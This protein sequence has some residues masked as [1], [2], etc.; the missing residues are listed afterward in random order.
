VSGQNANA[1]SPVR[2]IPAI[3]VVLS[4]AAA[5]LGVASAQTLTAD[6][7]ARH[8]EPPF[9]LGEPVNDKGVWTIV[10]LDGTE[11]GFIF[12]T[13]PLAPIPGFSG[14]PVNVLVT[15]DR[16]GRFLDAELIGHNEPIFVSGLGPEP[17]HA[18]IAQHKGLSISDSISIGQPYGSAERA[19]SHVYIDGVAK[20]T[21]SVR[22]AH[23]SI[24]A[25]ALAVAREK[26]KGVSTGPSPR[27]DP[28]YR[29]QLT[30]DDLVNQG[31]VRHLAV[32]NAEVDAAFAGSEW[33]FD[34]PEAAANPQALYIDLWAVDIGPPSIAAAVLTESSLDSLRRFMEVSTF[35]EPILVIETARHGL[36]G[37]E[38]TRNTV[39]DSISAEQ[40]GLPVTLRDADRVIETRAG[41]PQGRALILRTDRRL[42]FDP[43]RPWTLTL[44][45]VRAHG[46]FMPTIGQRPFSLEIAAPERFFIKP[47]A[48]AQPLPAWQE[49]II[50]RAPDLAAAGLLL[51]L[52]VPAML[53]GQSRMAALNRRPIARLAVLAVTIGFIGWWGQGQLS[54]ATPLGILRTLVDGGSLSF[55]LYDPFS[56]LIWTVVIMSFVLWGRGLFCGWLCPYGA[57]QEFT[58]YAGRKLGLTQ[59]ALPPAW[60]ARLVYLKYL[61]LAGMVVAALAVPSLLD[62]LIEIEPFKTAITTFFV[63][64]WW[65]VAYAVFWLALSAVMFKGFCRYIC[66]L[67]AVM[68]IGGF[69]RIRN[70]IPRRKACGSPCQL[71]KVR[72]NYGAIKPS[73]A[74]AYQECFACL[75]CVTIH[76]DPR[77][78]VPLVL[79]ARGRSL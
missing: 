29:E 68:A 34:D 6:E 14:A 10:N 78:C 61:I 20:A 63:R 47:A 28:D 58:A 25:A 45:A 23:Q 79:A 21:A 40:D 19:S 75:D 7:L 73:G 57:M 65:F 11:S 76:D 52:F 56:L 62:A 39:P 26:M 2:L 1:A 12:E 44:Q 49:A 70:W 24:L 64:E 71:C 48:P 22:I 69:L 66:P 50:N 37:E 46:S 74:I 53:F 77:Q 3:G 35:D 51:S 41:V 59:I 32:T 55:L 18:F 54:I 36:V 33:A 30:W 13:E 60:D 72:C 5:W 38:F 8:I 43:T 9:R 16:D 31:I 27:P 17:F 42:G 67:G 4:F 15:I